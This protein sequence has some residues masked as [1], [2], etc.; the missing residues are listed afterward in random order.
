VRVAAIRTGRVPGAVAGHGRE[1]CAPTSA[2]TYTFDLSI[3]A[4]DGRA[5]EHWSGL[6]LQVVGEHAPRAW[7]RALVGPYL[8]RRLS[9]LL[10]RRFDVSVAPSTAVRSAVEPVRQDGQRELLSEVAH[11]TRARAA[12]LTLHVTAGQRVG[13]D[14]EAVGARDWAGLLGDDG[15]HLARAIGCSAAEEPDCGATRVWAAREAGIKA[16][17]PR[18]IALSLDR[19][20]DGGWVVLRSGHR[21]VATVVL[22]TGTAHLAI[23]VATE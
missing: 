11:A 3:R 1:Q 23:A 21:R 12:G 6:E 8:S 4:P 18:P 19:T 9:E 10:G 13:C 7:P 5:I 16:G 2:G 15:V 14:L 22:R 20:S 17:W